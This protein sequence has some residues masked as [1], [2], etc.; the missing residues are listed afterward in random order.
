MQHTDRVNTF[1]SKALSYRLESIALIA[2]ALLLGACSSDPPQVR[3]DIPLPQ[4]GTGGQT[5]QGTYAVILRADLALD[6]PTDAAWDVV[7]QEIVPALT[8]GAWRGNGLRL[9]I[10]RREQRDAYAAA[11]PL[12]VSG[13]RTLMSQSGHPVPI[14]QTPMLNSDLLFEVDLTRPPMPR[15]VENIV[16][17]NNS[18]LRLL[19]RIETEEDGRHTLILTPQHHI[20]SPYNLIPRDP[21]QKE[22]DGRIFD[23]LTVRLTLEEGD[24]AVVGL[25]WPWPMQEVLPSETSERANGAGTSNGEAI[26]PVSPT[27]SNSSDP[28]APPSHITPTAPNASDN[29]GPRT[30]PNDPEVAAGED[31]K[32]RYERVAPPLPTHLGSMLFTG[33]RIRQPVQRVLLITIEAQKDR[34]PATDTESP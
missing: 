15:Q 28:A 29:N 10:L 24:I 34:E 16:G 27:R 25:H 11:M 21:L 8:R 26:A 12:R 9:G 5:P 19:A 20:P 31:Q 30:K 22:L 18:T 6:A 1:G 23:E 32:P 14:I 33:T 7:N 4:I 2:I 13:G 17:G 3:E